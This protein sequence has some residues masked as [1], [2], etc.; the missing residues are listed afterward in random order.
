[1]KRV[2][3]IGRLGL[4]DLPLLA[5]LLWAAVVR[6]PVGAAGWY[7][8]ERLRGNGATMPTLTAYFTTGGA[9]VPDPGVELPPPPAE[10]PPAAALPE[11]W[12]TATRAA[13]AGGVP[14][15]AEAEILARGLADRPEPALALADE[16]YAAGATV[17]EALEIV[18]IGADLRA[19]AVARAVAAGDA[20]PGAW[21][22]H[23]R[24]LSGGDRRE[25]DRV[26][27]GALGLATVLDLAWPVENA[28]ITSGFGERTHPV[29]GTRKLHN[30]VDLAA[31]I[32]TPVR[33]AQAGELAVVGEDR[34]NGRFAVIDHGHGIRSSY[35]HLNA[36]DGARG[37]ILG[38]AQ[39]F[40]ASGNTGRSTGPHLHFTL[41]IGGKA[42]DPVRYGPRP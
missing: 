4:V 8:A 32:G 34:V 36:V 18:A 30:G 3:R 38:R 33:A 20:D 12:R 22:T 35:C 40:A 14:A 24:W 26:V 42:V 7:A 6:T 28:R 23:R 39:V 1:M 15:A 25:G 29:L 31:P 37:D 10:P 9:A 2:A 16:L 19:R 17:E 13:L 27:G 11:P 21:A 5:V 41:K